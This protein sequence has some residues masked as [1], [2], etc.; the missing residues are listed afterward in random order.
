MAA[1]NRKTAPI[2]THE[3]GKASHINPEQQLRRLVMSCMLWEQSFYV[4]GTT[5]A[6]QIQLTIPKVDPLKVVKIAVEA[7][8]K[9]NLR[10]VPLLIV[11]EMARLPAY[12][13]YVS[14]TLQRVIQRPD[15][16]SEFLAIYWAGKRAPLSAKV[17]Q[18]LAQAF[19]KF[20]EYALAK[21]NRDGAIK[22]R[23][24]LF[25]CHAKPVDETQD[26]L[27][28][29]LIKNELV[30]PDTWEVQLSGGADKKEVF[31]RLMSEN[32]LGALA[33]LRNLRNMREAKVDEELIKT[34][35]NQVFIDKVLPYRFIAAAQ[36]NP[37]F[38]PI[39]ENM[40]Y[41]SVENK[42]KLKGKTILLI[43]NSGSM[44]NP[45]SQKSEMKCI[46]AA[47]ALAILLRELCDS[48]HVYAFSDDCKLVPPRR[49][50]ALRDAIKSSLHP[51]ST[52]LGKALHH[53][54]FTHPAYDRVII[55]TDEQ[56]SDS[57]GKPNG[58]GYILNVASNQNG[59][60]YAN[61]MHI[62][63][64]SSAVIEYIQEYENANNSF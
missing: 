47:C 26:A 28:K 30:T 41:R 36:T 25:L 9:M 13:R 14:R 17:K 56:T 16:L 61:F 27:W 46:D 10:H 20:D 57:V 58:K 31:E 12:K 19:T 11:R 32:K 15:E 21:Y 40:L 29:R 50:F 60:G 35:S 3:G 22:L 37:Q 1:L 7:R 64:F 34:Y 24:V 5:I 38:E 53:V 6:E 49:G 51:C 55:I 63:G 59:V 39:L 52:N 44:G 23:D 42:A 8:E 4:D 48:V 45:M 2:V 33:F 43:D 18:G 54:N 62:N